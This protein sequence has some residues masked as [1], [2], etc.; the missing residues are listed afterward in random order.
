[1]NKTYITSKEMDIIAE[2]VLTKAGVST[3]WQGVVNK[4]DIDA[5][6]EFEYG[7]EIVWEDIDYLAPCESVFAAIVPKRKVIYMNETKKS[8]F[9]DKMGTMNF[10]KAHE[11][12]H[13]ILHV[14]EQKD[15]L[16]LT[17]EECETFFCRSASKKS[18]QEIQADMFAASI[19]MPR[20]II[21]SAINK[22]K[23]RGQVTFPD[24]Y[25]L[26]G[27]FEVSISAFTNRVKNLKLL[28]ITDDKKIFLN[29]A[30]ATGQLSLL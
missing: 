15:Y 5:L 24:L 21:S 9:K 26:Q 2:S 16:Q 10:S 1:M 17:F 3:V 4:V 30:E 12:G 25:Q 8:L 13:W 29:E 23:Q 18:S 19:L 22:L 28:Y 27:E 14:T 11:L 6:I 7:L 20:N